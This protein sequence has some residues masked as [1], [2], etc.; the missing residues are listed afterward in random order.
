MEQPSGDWFGTSLHAS[1]EVVSRK[2]QIEEFMFLGLRMND[3]VTR[4]DFERNF[5]VPIETVYQNVLNQLKAQELIVA[6][7]GRIALTERGMDLGNYVS[8]KFML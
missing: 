2:E 8:S 7:G 1:A 6:L 4:A 3:G 5:G